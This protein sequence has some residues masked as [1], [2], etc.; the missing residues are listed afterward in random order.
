MSIACQSGHSETA[1]ILLDHSA[2][3]DY[4]D[5]VRMSMNVHTFQSQKLSRY[6]DKNHDFM[7]LPPQKGQS[8]LVLACVG[9]HMETVKVL[10]ESKLAQV[11]LQNDVR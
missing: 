2:D 11:D 10:L 8:P 6:I 3:I 4:Q 1:R 5:K 9:G 7:V